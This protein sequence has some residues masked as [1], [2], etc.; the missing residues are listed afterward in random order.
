[1]FIG[2][3]FG[4]PLFDKMDEIKEYAL[5]VWKEDPTSCKRTINETWIL[6][7]RGSANKVPKKW[8]KSDFVEETIDLV[9]V[10]SRVMGLPTSSLFEEWMFYFLEEILHGEAKF[11]YAKIKNMHNQFVV[12]K[13]NLEFYMTCYLV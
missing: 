7:K 5:N 2:K 10:L 9:M 1:M 11:H 6:E 3:M 13:K 4:I 8:Y 12:V